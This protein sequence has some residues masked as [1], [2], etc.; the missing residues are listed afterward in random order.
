MLSSPV[1]GEG[2][3]RDPTC[4]LTP[5]LKERKT[6]CAYQVRARSLAP[7][8]QTLLA[9]FLR[10]FSGL[11]CSWRASG[12]G[13]GSGGS[14]QSGSGPAAVALALP[15]QRLEHVP[16]SGRRS[17]KRSAGLAPTPAARGGG[18]HNDQGTRDSVGD[19]CP[20][21]SQSRCPGEGSPRLPLQLSALLSQPLKER[22]CV[23]RRGWC[24]TQKAAGG[25]GR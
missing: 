3:R 14:K 25:A 8:R 1:L 20:E 21:A 22:S 18:R 4:V 16:H 15:R 17:W 10:S 2:L 23:G 5:E 19:K 12:G 9:G 13:G 6:R 24:V 7:P 11:S